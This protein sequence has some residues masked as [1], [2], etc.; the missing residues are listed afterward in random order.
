MA[1][2]TSAASGDWSASATWGKAGDPPVEGTDFPG[3][4]DAFVIAAGHTVTFDRDNSGHANGIAG[5]TITSHATTPGRLKFKSNA[6][7]T[8]YLKVKTNTNIAGT[9]AAVLGQLV[10]GHIAAIT[11]HT[12]VAANDAINETSTT[13]SN[14]DIITFLAGSGTLPAP[15]VGNRVY[16]VAGKATNS[17]KVSLTH[18]GD[19]ID[20][21]TDGSGTYEYVSSPGVGRKQVIELNG[22]GEI[23]GQYLTLLSVCNE[24]TNLYVT[25]YGGTGSALTTLTAVTVS[26]SGGNALFTMG[27]GSIANTTPVKLTAAA[28]PG[29]FTATDLYYVVGTSGSTFKLALTSGGAACR[30]HR[31]VPRFKHTRVLP[32]G[33]ARGSATNCWCSKTLRPPIRCGAPRLRSIRSFLPTRDRRTKT[34]RF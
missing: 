27:S 22:T 31:P 18:D 16:Y 14:G 1:T 17:F 34:L 10:M 2:F 5:G 32:A 30:I 11:N 6:D 29:G 3:D 26:D 4:S 12:D 23:T 19:A 15:L 13:R 7:G 21:T 33:T 8:Y 9:D 25:P 20:L 24:P 28:L